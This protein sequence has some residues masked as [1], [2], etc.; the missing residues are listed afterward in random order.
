MT[1]LA[2]LLAAIYYMLGDFKPVFDEEQ[3][4]ER[5]N[6]KKRL[7]LRGTQDSLRV[8]PQVHKS[9]QDDFR[10][11]MAAYEPTSQVDPLPNAGNRRIWKTATY[12]EH[13]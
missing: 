1:T 8:V 12:F 4:V 11:L 6:L 2:I 5:F 3:S 9:N 7:V 13:R 10:S